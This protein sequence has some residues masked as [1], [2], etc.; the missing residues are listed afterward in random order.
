MIAI[1]V[2]RLATALPLFALS[3]VLPTQGQAAP[4]A[5]QIAERSLKA[6][7]YAGKDTRV[8]VFMTL[9][10]AAGKTRHRK[11][12]LLRKNMGKGGEQR[13]YVFFHAPADVKGT[14]FMV[15]KHPTKD[16]DRWIFMPAI[17]LVRRI[18]A[19]DKR[20][21]FLGS[22]FT[23]EDLSG[24]QVDDETH[25]FMWEEQVDGRNCYVLESKPKGN[26]D[27]VRRLS[28][29]DKKT[30]L[31][32]KEEYYDA[33][34]KR[35]RE[36]FGKEIKSMGGHPT[37]L[38]RTMKNLQTGHHTVVRLKQVVYDLGLKDE[39]FSE[40]YLRQPPQDQMR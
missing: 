3:L 8:R 33:R 15:W 12:T 38:H 23:Y 11:I 30:Y 17:N 16:D 25:R 21:S 14:T 27:Y 28:W 37:V 18:A 4:A 36:F 5:R 10:N 29:I 34:R 22:D 13:Y 35:I 32:L 7:Y 20:S 26:L 19:S 40:R 39:I 1:P 31:P 9:I 2:R 6:F 24:R